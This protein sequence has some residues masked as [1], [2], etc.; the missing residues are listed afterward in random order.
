MLGAATRAAMGL[1]REA[2]ARA[3]T[4]VAAGARDMVVRDAMVMGKMMVSA[5]A[6]VTLKAR[7]A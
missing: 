4:E 5:P 7:L 6:Y 3:D 2:D 1:L